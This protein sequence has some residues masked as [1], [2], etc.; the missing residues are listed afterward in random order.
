MT[1]FFA[2]DHAGYQ[3]KGKLLEFV[4]E[5]GFEVNDCGAF[6]LDPKDDYPDF[7]KKAAQSVSENPENSKAIILGG[8]GQG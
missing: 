1:I 2:S 6:K 3:L 7:I 8:S 5:L 4:K